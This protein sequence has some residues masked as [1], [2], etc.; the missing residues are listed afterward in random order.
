ML[1]IRPLGPRFGR[2]TIR[3]PLILTL[4]MRPYALVTLPAFRHDVHT[5]TRFGV[6]FTIARTR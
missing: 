6:P 4:V 2:R 3:A 1:R 5:F